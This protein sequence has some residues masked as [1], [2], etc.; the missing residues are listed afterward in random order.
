MRGLTIQINCL[1][2]VF[3]IK[4]ERCTVKD[5][6]PYAKLNKLVNKFYSI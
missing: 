4:S 3:E 5:Y 1:A 6:M 2:I